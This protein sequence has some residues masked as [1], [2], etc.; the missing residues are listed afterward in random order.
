MKSCMNTIPHFT[1]K[2]KYVSN[3]VK[4]SRAKLAPTQK[5]FLRRCLSV[6]ALL[7]LK[8]DILLRTKFRIARRP[9]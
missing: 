5:V 1:K 6:F 2:I 4:R 9:K 7:R 3:V 8:P